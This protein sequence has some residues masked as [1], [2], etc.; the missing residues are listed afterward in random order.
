MRTLTHVVPTT[1]AVALVLLVGIYAAY[2]IGA[3]YVLPLP[4]PLNLIPVAGLLVL[5]V[6]LARRIIAVGLR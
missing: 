1:L 3:G 6:G 4:P 5:I 2:A